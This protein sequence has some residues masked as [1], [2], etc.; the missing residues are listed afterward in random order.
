MARARRDTRPSNDIWPGFVDA[1]STLLM[2]FIFL[3]TVFVLAQFFLSQLIAGRDERLRTLQDELAVV[4]ADREEGR[5]R[6]DDLRRTVARLS[7]ELGIARSERD[8]AEADRDAVLSERDELSSRLDRLGDQNLLLQRTL[9]NLEADA[10]E[11]EAARQRIEQALL[12]AER[13]LTADSATIEA[14]LDDLV[15]L[16]QD[17][18]ALQTLRDRLEAEIAGVVEARDDLLVQL[19]VERDRN[20]ALADELADARERT[21]LTQTEFDREA[22]RARIAVEEVAVLNEQ[23]AELRAGLA[24]LEALLASREDVIEAQRIRIDDL[25]VRL[26]AALAGQVDELL[27]FRS[28]FFGRLRQV[29]GGREDVRIE[30]DR[31]VFQS[32]LLFAPGEAT[33]GPDARVQLAAL[34]ETL[35]GLAADLP[36][37]LPWILQVDGHTDVTPIAT[38]RFPSNWELSAARAISV[39]RYLV[40]QGLPSDR[41]AAAGF[42][43]FQPLDDGDDEEAYRRNRRI[44]LKLTTR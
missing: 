13:R 40:G 21:L 42:A 14:Q 23:L 35:L 4:E 1:L 32:E 5:L 38:A 10:D 3:L 43:E 28:E 15:R 34:A 11:A 9:A 20:L 6:L 33:L 18:E 2:V 30:G 12:D 39:A 24:R 25:D 8:D 27:Q 22:A 16:R 44:E 17:I 29:L 31:F 37:D 36:T 26:T 19:G 41:V 7:A